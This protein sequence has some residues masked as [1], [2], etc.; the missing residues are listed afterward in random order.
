MMNIL[1]RKNAF[2]GY[3]QQNAL[4][5]CNYMHALH[6]QICE[7]VNRQMSWINRENDNTNIERLKQYKLPVITNINQLVNALCISEEQEKIFFYKELR[8]KYLYRIVRIPKRSGG[9]RELEIPIESLKIIQKSIN[10]VILS[11]FKMSKEA[12]AYIKKR[13][14]VTNAAP[15]VGAKTI[16]KIDIKDFFPSINFKHVY[17]QFRYFGYGENV[18]KYLSLLCVDGDLKLPQGAPTS[19]TLSNLISVYMDSRISGYC[20]KYN[21]SYTR[22]ADDITI[23]SKE[24]LPFYIIMSIKNFIFMILRDLG[25]E[26]NETK[27]KYFYN[28]SRLEVTG[29]NVNSKLS[30]PK[31]KIREMENAI[32]YIDKYGLEN[33]M[34]YL[35]I[36]KKDYVG[37]LYGL[38]YY[39]KMIDKKKG[40]VYIQALNKLNI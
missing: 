27:F 4:F 36:N 3:T 31:D 18:S 14:I 17:G 7:G 9:I 21:Y 16:I 25:F 35:K 10:V 15:H 23:S 33:H 34:Q 28:G 1:L 19:P 24:K 39:I 2:A 13:S 38:A 32:R 37:H 11:R 40:E 6:A 8:K 29:I 22:Y 5:S 26:P 12:N 20:V 30:V